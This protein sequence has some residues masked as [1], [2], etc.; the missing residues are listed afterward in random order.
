M[1]WMSRFSDKINQ[2]QALGQSISDS[3][4]HEAVHSGLDYDYKIAM[5]NASTKRQVDATTAMNDKNVALKREARLQQQSQF[6]D[7]M[8]AQKEKETY[9]SIGNVATAAI[10]NSEKIGQAYDWITGKPTPAFKDDTGPTMMKESLT[11]TTELNTQ[12]VTTGSTPETSAVS[13]EPTPVATSESAV[14]E[15]ALGESMTAGAED[16]IGQGTYEATIA[17]LGEGTLASTMFTTAAESGA[18]VAL[19]IA[20][21]EGTASLVAGGAGT[22]LVAEASGVLTAVAGA[23]PV[24][25]ILGMVFMAC[26]FIFPGAMSKIFSAVGDAIDSIFGGSVVC[27]ELNR[28]GYISDEVLI[29]E[30]VYKTRHIDGETYNGY[31]K[32]FTPVVGLMKKSKIITQIVRPFG[33]GVANELAHRINDKYKPS[34][35]GK[36]VLKIGLPLCKIVGKKAEK[37]CLNGCY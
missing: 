12:P 29:M 26:S 27:T 4:I 3:A 25:P 10:T 37:R 7:N 28:Q 8:A 32:L 30:G 9:A 17:T 34:L 23:M 24:V 19:E 22:S 20:A 2:K 6:D 15:S 21:A 31:L 1:D 18:S 5:Q 14:S 16:F 11:S 36:L 35:L 13:Y 33:V